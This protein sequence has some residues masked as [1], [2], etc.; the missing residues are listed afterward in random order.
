AADV[1][2]QKYGRLSAEEPLDRLATLQIGQATVDDGEATDAAE[3]AF[4]SLERA[5]EFGEEDERL[6]RAIGHAANPRELRLAA[7]G[8]SRECAQARERGTFERARHTRVGSGRHPLAVG[9]RIVSEVER[10]LGPLEIEAEWT[11]IE[12]VDPVRQRTVER[13]HGRE[14]AF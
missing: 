13:G 9:E 14:R 1:G 2:G 11:G 6:A 8:R 3:N 7:H 10:W 4:D 5:A 12:P